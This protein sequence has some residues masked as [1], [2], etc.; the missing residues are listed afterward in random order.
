MEE[1]NKKDEEERKSD[2]GPYYGNVYSEGGSYDSRNDEGTRPNGVYPENGGYYSYNGYNGNGT[3]NDQNPYGNGGGFGAPQKPPKKQSNLIALIIAV[4]VAASLIMC[5][6]GFVIGFWLNFEPEVDNTPGE[7]LVGDQDDKNDD[8]A[9]GGNTPSNDLL[10]E[11]F[12]LEQVTSEEHY[13]FSSVFNLTKNM[14]V[15]ITTESVTTGSFMQQYVTTGA[16]SGVIIGVNKERAV[17]YIVTN[18][19]V[20]DGATRITVTLS[21][22]T[23]L[24][25]SVIGA[26]QKTDIAVIAVS[27]KVKDSDGNDKT[28]EPD[29]AKL[30]ISSNILV[31]EEVLIIGNPLGSLGGSASNGII[32]ATAR[33]ISVEGQMMTLIQ[34]NAAV[35]PGNSGGAMFDLSGNLI[36]IVNA[37]YTDEAVE[38]IGFAIP[39]D[40]AKPIIED[41]IKNG[42]V[43]G[44]PNLGITAEYGTYISSVGETNWITAIE[45]GSDAEKA[46][47]KAKDQIVSVNEQTFTSAEALNMYLDTLKIG[48]TVTFVVK[49]YTVKSQSMWGTQYS[50]E[51]LT[52]TFTLTEYKLG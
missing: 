5:A 24:S 4:C 39:I 6:L 22:E 52:V 38:G 18:N 48:D 42:Y 36:G 14:V 20:I 3:Y 37:K 31:G 26:D 16:G 13:R 43:T 23:M 28:L 11:N 30:G 17:A 50:S 40:T 21:D 12:T 47:L 8:G 2:N 15:E 45:S 25:A 41:L 9:S 1:N 19:H 46:G 27:L 33:Q 35:N 49:R 44:R 10:D 32:S 34:T 29:I 7:D 51:T